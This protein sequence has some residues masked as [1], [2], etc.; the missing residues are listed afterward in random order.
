MHFVLICTV[1]VLYE[2]CST[3]TDRKGNRTAR[4]QTGDRQRPGIGSQPH[5][6]TRH[7][8]LHHNGINATA[9]LVIKEKGENCATNGSWNCL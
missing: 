6:T 7:H 8:S 4:Y 9:S 1:V 3:D 5:A 2:V